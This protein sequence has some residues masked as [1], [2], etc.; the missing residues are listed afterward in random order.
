[1]AEINIGQFSEAFNDKADIDLQNVTQEGWDTVQ[2]KL[3]ASS[4][5][6]VTATNNTS[7]SITAGDKVW[8]NTK[9]LDATKVGGVTVN[10]Y[11]D[12][13]NFS[14]SNGIVL[15]NTLALGTADTWEFVTKIKKT[16][17]GSI[18]S[19][20]TC[21]SAP[22]GLPEARN[23]G[24][25]MFFYD[26]GLKPMVEG[27]YT[28]DASIGAFSIISDTDIQL[29][30]DTYIKLEFTGTAYNLY[31]SS[32]GATWTNV[33]TYQ[34]STKIYQQ[35][36][37]FRFGSANNSSNGYYFVGTIY[38]GETYWKING[39]VVWSGAK[40]L[41]P[42]QLDSFSTINGYSLTG[43]AQENIASGS[44]GDVLTLLGE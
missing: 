32:N 34:S 29:N 42:P 27:V 5:D 40:T 19:F 39:Q 36:E 10:E 17:T 24:I 44:T 11:F 12:A 8:I 13:S 37:P 2:E 18:V 31:I 20:V 35:T 41:E 16:G 14:S 6:I 7:S 4:G 23:S 28:R 43:F 30:T 33:G 15:P 26:G 25:Y 22:G 9:Q 38:M 1:M 21:G 3:K